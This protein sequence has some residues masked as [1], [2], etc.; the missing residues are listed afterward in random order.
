MKQL[1]HTYTVSVRAAQPGNILLHHD[2]CS[3]IE[4]DAPVEFDGPGHRWSPEA[5]LVAAAVSC[6]AITFRGLARRYKL[7]WTS[8]NCDASGVLDR[9]DQQLR[10]TGIGIHATLTLPDGADAER[11]RELL[12]RADETC[13]IA[14]SLTATRM[15]TVDVLVSTQPAAA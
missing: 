4:T 9:S 12:S 6:F 5:L 11:A 7:G 15:L 14:N 13:L 10:F 1:P 3:P 2:G 8:L